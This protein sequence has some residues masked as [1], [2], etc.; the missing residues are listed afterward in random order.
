[1]SLN[2][3]EA[4]ILWGIGMFLWGLVGS[5]IYLFF[6]YLKPKWLKIV[7]YCLI[8]LGFITLLGSSIL[9]KIST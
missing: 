8:V 3:I 5:F 4:G 1:M 9:Y 2:I 6:S 7:S